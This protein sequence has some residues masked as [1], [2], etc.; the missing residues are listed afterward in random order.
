MTNSSPF[1]DYSRDAL[2]VELQAMRHVADYQSEFFGNLPVFVVYDSK[3]QAFPPSAICCCDLA[4]WTA[5]TEPGILVSVDPE[6]GR[7][8]FEGAPPDPVRVA[9]A[10]AF[11]GP[12][13]GGFYGGGPYGG[14]GWDNA[15]WGGGGCG[16]CCRVWIPPPPPPPPCCCCGGWGRG[17]GGWDGGGWGGGGYDGW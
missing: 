1:Y 14:G 10:Y 4:S 6:L 13:G 9:Y 8:M 12:Y 3:G 11:G 17:R 15:G 2:Y 16:C 5:P 7:L